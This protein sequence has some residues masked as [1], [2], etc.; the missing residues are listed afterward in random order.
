LLGP[1]GHIATPLR[2]SR[3][4]FTPFRAPGMGEHAHDVARTLCGLSDARIAELEQAGV[5]Q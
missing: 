5:F 1:F 3:D 2:F 4:A